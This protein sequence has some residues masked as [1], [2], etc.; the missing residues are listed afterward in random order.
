MIWRQDSDPWPHFS[1]KWRGFGAGY[2]TARQ[3]WEATAH[4]AADTVTQILSGD[5]RTGGLGE[6][7]SLW[8]AEP[9]SNEHGPAILSPSELARITLAESIVKQR[10]SLTRRIARCRERLARLELSGL[11]GNFVGDNLDW[12]K[13]NREIGR[14][15]RE[16]RA[17]LDWLL[18]E[19]RALN[20]K[21]KRL[22]FGFD[23]NSKESRD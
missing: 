16:Q 4:E 3:L 7:R 11:L 22:G 1:R 12:I 13:H 14:K 6:Y 17:R 19:L 9:E 18:D 23:G 15:T 20:R 21:A 10:A 8:Q 2:P 5:G